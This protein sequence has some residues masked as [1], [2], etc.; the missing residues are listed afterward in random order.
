MAVSYKIQRLAAPL[1][2]PQNRKMGKKARLMVRK[3]RYWPTDDTD[4]RVISR[5]YGSQ[6]MLDHFNLS[7]PRA[8]TFAQKSYS[9][10]VCLLILI[11]EYIRIFINNILTIKCLQ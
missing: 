6:F 1:Y 10:F 7:I 5:Y 11:L 3:I 4:S 2:K 8:L 9:K